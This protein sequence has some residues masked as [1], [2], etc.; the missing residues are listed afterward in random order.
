MNI[1]KDYSG[2]SDAELLYR[3]YELSLHTKFNYLLNSISII[4]LRMA[5]AIATTRN[6][7]ELKKIIQ[8]YIIKKN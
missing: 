8:P 2:Q 5:Y 7:Q 3:A 1:I 4:E 6:M